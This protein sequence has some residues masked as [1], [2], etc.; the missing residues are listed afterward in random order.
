MYSVKQYSDLNPLLGCNWH[1]RGIN[2]RMNFCYVNLR[3]VRYYLYKRQ[4]LIDFTASGKQEIVSGHSLIF[5]FVRMDG[6]Q[7]DWD[8]VADQD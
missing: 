1:V 4:P 8:T 3:S 7:E 2:D 5:K 6:V